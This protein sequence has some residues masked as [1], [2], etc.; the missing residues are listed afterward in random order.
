MNATGTDSI[1]DVDA[2]VAA[3][4]SAH[5]EGTQVELPPVPANRETILAIQ[6]GV[7]AGLGPVA[8]FKVGRR[9]DGALIV[10]PILARYMV[11]NGGTRR[12]ADRL[13]VE[14]EVGFEL[15]RALPD[16]GFPKRPQDHFRPC[17]VLELVDTRLA[18]PLAEDPSC[19]FADFQINAGLVIGDSRTDWDGSDFTT[20]A[21]R[22]VAG[23]RAILDGA[24]QVPGGSALEN[25]RALVEALGSHCGGLQQGQVVITGSL[26]GLPYFGPGTNILGRIDGL[27]AVSIALA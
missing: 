1:T 13:G 15:V 8:G 17:T 6:A 22:L 23:D 2:I 14:L 26:C 9:A 18:G 24:T 16:G 20:L 19:K 10:A 4:R 27:G 5:L 3:L 7:C 25:L 12:I 11:P 21:A